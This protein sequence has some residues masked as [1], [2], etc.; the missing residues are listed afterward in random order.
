MKKLISISF[1]L[2]ALTLILFVLFAIA[3]TILGPQVEQQ[4]AEQQA[5]ALILLVV[6]FIEVL[7]TAF[8]IRNSV[9]SGWHL[10]GARNNFV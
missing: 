8:V 3:A 4:P 7:V 6:C 10:S 2:V 1:R 9:W 5:G